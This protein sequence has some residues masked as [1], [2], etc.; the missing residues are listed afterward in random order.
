MLGIGG[1]SMIVL[2]LVCVFGI[3]VII[4]FLLDVKF[5]EF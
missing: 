3:K 2:K 5:E 1:V 4:S